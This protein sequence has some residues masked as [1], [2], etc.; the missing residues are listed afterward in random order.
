MWAFSSRHVGFALLLA[1]LFVSMQDFQFSYTGVSAAPL[2]NGKITVPQSIKRMGPAVRVW[3]SRTGNWVKNKVPNRATASNQRS[4]APNLNRPTNQGSGATLNKQK[5]VPLP[6][7]QKNQVSSPNT[8]KT[9]TSTSRDPKQ[10]SE[11]NLK[12][13]NKDFP[14]RGQQSK[15]EE[16]FDLDALSKKG[17]ETDSIQ[18]KATNT[19]RGSNTNLRGSN[20]DGDTGSVKTNNNGAKD[21]ASPSGNALKRESSLMTYT[22]NHFDA[23]LKKHGLAPTSSANTSLRRQKVIRRQFRHSLPLT[24]KDLQQQ[25]F[26]IQGLHVGLG[27][28]TIQGQVDHSVLARPQSAQIE[29]NPNWVGPE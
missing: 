26:S 7:S 9:A 6:A 8:Q 22:M 14:P 28:R 29:R 20:G 19:Q 21:S 3:G 10:Q 2:F 17:A 23:L 5:S 12:R 4:S 18:S 13:F 15:F 1:M 27:K 25:V 11:D 16:R 24:T